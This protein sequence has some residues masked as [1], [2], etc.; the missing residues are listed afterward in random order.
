MFGANYLAAPYFA[1]AWAGTAAR[2]VPPPQVTGS[3]STALSES[4]G[5]TGGYLLDAQWG[6]DRTLYPPGTGWTGVLDDAPERATEGRR[7][8]ANLLAV[9]L[10]VA[11]LDDPLERL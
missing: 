10:A 7:R 6:L 8:G 4:V 3:A 9:V 2:P 11:M 1:Q 5:A